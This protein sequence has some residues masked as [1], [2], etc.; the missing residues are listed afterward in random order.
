MQ[1]HII[2]KINMEVN[3]HSITKA[4][5]IKDHVNSFLNEELLPL[6]EKL[7]DDKIDPKKIKRFDTVNLRFNL[8]SL[9]HFSEL[10]TE[11]STQLLKYILEGEGKPPDTYD[12][13]FPEN[14]EVHSFKSALT[15]SENLENIFFYFLE[16]GQLPWHANQVHFS[17]FLQREKFV[18]RLGNNN[19]IQKLKSL[20]STNQEAIKR[21]VIQ[22]DDQLLASLLCRIDQKNRI[23][24]EKLHA[25]IRTFS[26]KIKEGF[27]LLVLS[28]WADTEQPVIE[29]L[30]KQLVKSIEDD[31]RQ[32]VINSNLG[33]LQELKT[34]DDTHGR[35][36]YLLSFFTVDKIIFEQVCNILKGSDI[37]IFQS[38]T[39]LLKSSGINFSEIPIS[40]K[41]IDVERPPTFKNTHLSKVFSSESEESFS[42][43]N[44]EESSTIGVKD[45]LAGYSGIDSAEAT[46]SVFIHEAE[47]QAIHENDIQPTPALS[48]QPTIAG[49]KKKFE[50][51]TSSNAKDDV[52]SNSFGSESKE[53]YDL[54]SEEESPTKGDKNIPATQSG[55]DS[56]EAVSS[57]FRQESEIQAIHENDIQPTPALSDQPTIAGLKKKFEAET[58]SNAKDDVQSNSFGSESKEGYDLKSEEESPTKGDKNI[59][60]TQSGLDSAEAVSSVFKQEAKKPAIP[61]IDIQPAPAL[62]NQST[63]AGLKKEL[64]AETSSNVKDEIQFASSSNDSEEGFGLKSEK[65]SS[66]KGD[67]DTLAAVSGIDLAK[68]VSQRGEQKTKES[69]KVEDQFHSDTT[70]TDFSAVSRFQKNKVAEEFIAERVQYHK[71]SI[72]YSFQSNTLLQANEVY[73]NNAGLILVHPFLKYLFLNTGITNQEGTLYVSKKSEA[74]H[75]LHFLATGL[76]N[77]FEYLLTF[78]KFLCGIPFNQSI[79]REIDLPDA[80]KKEC[81]ELLRSVIEQ[82]PVLKNTSS[83]GLRQMFIQR[84]GKL[85]Q[86]EDTYKLIVDRKAQDVLLEKLNWTISMFKLPW[87]NKLIQVEW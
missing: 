15:T 25:E 30:A 81:E 19:F 46:S 56:A 6:L 18:K 7:F 3:S 10:K 73:V 27:F 4:Y 34:S 74:V 47:I 53:G 20:C 61:E 71:E 67:K 31:Q 84:E 68:N 21:L 75:L 42:L 8:K 86:K 36:I 55:L 82:W 45:M 22:F 87:I 9:D 52:Q 5:Y 11:I 37:S 2:H 33:K 59:P 43:K 40:E 58:S 35:I 50:A 32:L 60:A 65:W 13:V 66:I 80:W 14:D 70:N 44:E 1:N 76:E 83:D 12:M 62:S 16:T 24:K 38:D 17:T 54:K 28:V 64:K 41:S 85:I 63:I 29:K 72:L 49:L 77:E 79:E 23:T 78:E 39:V 48:D 69:I 26:K 51:E 57:V